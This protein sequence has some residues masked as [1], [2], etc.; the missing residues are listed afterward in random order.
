MATTAMVAAATIALGACGGGGGGGGTAS[1]G[2]FV[3]GTEVP[4]GVEQGIKDV[5]AFARQLIAAT[6]ETSEPVLLGN[7]KLATSESDEPADL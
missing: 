1:G 3:D 7:A 4:V 2:G 6:S 5:I